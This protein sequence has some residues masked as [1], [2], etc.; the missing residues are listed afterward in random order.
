MI[1]TVLKPSQN[2]Q[3]RKRERERERV[4]SVLHV[5]CRNC[6]Y[7]KGGGSRQEKKIP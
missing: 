3:E 6:Y 7:S 5:A 4:R 1:G 2:L